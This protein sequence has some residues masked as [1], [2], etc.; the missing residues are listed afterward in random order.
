TAAAVLGLPSGTATGTGTIDDGASRIGFFEHGAIPTGTVR[1]ALI[2]LIQAVDK[3]GKT[4][5]ALA[6]DTFT[7][8]VTFAGPVTFKSGTQDTIFAKVPDADAVLD[9]STA[10][11]FLLP[12]MNAHRKYTLA[13]PTGG[14]RRIRVLRLAISNF[15]ANFHRQD[16]GMVGFPPNSQAWAEFTHFDDGTGARWRP[17][18]WG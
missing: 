6:G 3:L 16:S 7:G 14:A 2:G 18:A 12:I 4:K 15:G 9:A 13:E 5:A 10:N 11:V 17:T 1:S 8:P